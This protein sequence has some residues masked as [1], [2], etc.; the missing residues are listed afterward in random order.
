[1]KFNRLDLLAATERAIAAYSERV[2]ARHAEAVAKHEAALA[3]WHEK[4]DQTWLDFFNEARKQLKKG[5]PIKKADLPQ[6]RG[7]HSGWTATFDNSPP[8]KDRVNVPRDLT[9][10]A[11]VL[12]AVTEDEVTQSGLRSLGITTTALRNAV[13]S[14]HPELPV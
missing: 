14:L 3:D 11:S 9:T 1:M 5:V 2:D 8:V 13:M 10:L 7:Y 6:E 12:R 4:Y